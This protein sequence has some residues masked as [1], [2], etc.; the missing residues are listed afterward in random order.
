M[1]GETIFLFYLAKE[2]DVNIILKPIGLIFSLWIEVYTRL[3]RA[4]GRDTAS[5]LVSIYYAIDD[6]F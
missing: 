4:K 1:R 5:E 3:D 6:L 2:F